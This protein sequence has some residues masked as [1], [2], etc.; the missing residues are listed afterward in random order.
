M[1][2]FL[3]IMLSLVAI[4]MI[5][6]ILVQRGKG[7]GLV[8][9]LGGM[10]GQSAFGTKAGDTFTRVTMWAAFVWIVLSAITVWYLGRKGTSVESD[11]GQNLP[12]PPASRAT[13]P[14]N[15]AGAGT[16]APS[17]TTP[18]TSTPASGT[19]AEKSDKK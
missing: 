15:P 18:T 12:A 17:S 5:L 3:A 9:A 1:S 7:G 13:P 16:S 2:T 19:P 10:G 4:F 6:L 8:G 14:E 11:A